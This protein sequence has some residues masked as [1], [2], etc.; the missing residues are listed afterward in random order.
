MT[1][2]IGTEEDHALLMASIFRTVKHED[3]AEFNK[4]A[5]AMKKAKTNKKIKEKKELL[6]VK[7]DKKLPGQEEEE[8][9][10]EEQEEAPTAQ[11]TSVGFGS[12]KEEKVEVETIDDRVFICLGKSTDGLEK[13]QVWVM[14]IN[15]T[16]DTVTF[17]EV[18]NHKHYVLKGRIQKEEIKYLESYMSP[19]ISKEEREKIMKNREFRKAMSMAESM[20]ALDEFKK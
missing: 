11:A 3:N 16:F 2:K 20:G 1:I 8:A 14:T 13:K 12:K 4:W 19:N 7:I 6:N 10:E 5:K 17:W 18:K 9:D 15:R